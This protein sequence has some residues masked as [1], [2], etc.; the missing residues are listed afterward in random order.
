MLSALFRYNIHV[1]VNVNLTCII[2]VYWIVS[3][4]FKGKYRQVFTLNGVVVH[5][6]A[7]LHLVD[8]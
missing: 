4:N 2:S 5:F 7:I 3:A 6:I 8:L 1:N